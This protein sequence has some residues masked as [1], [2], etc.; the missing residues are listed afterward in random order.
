MASETSVMAIN[1]PSVASDSLGNRIRRGGSDRARSN[2]S[3]AMDGS[4]AGTGLSRNLPGC[5]SRRCSSSLKSLMTGIGAALAQ[6][7][8][9]EPL[10]CFEPV[11][12]AEVVEIPHLL[13]RMNN[14]DV[15]PTGRPRIEQ[16][17]VRDMADE[18]RGLAPGHRR[19]EQAGLEV[20]WCVGVDD[21]ERRC[22]PR[23]DEVRRWSPRT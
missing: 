19:Y 2:K 17:I 18:K 7:Y 5:L 23:S 15:W 8:A 9:D 21:C 14:W 10:C 4:L 13:D 1:P 22:S 6:R 11:L 16:R 20:E 3:S 12:T